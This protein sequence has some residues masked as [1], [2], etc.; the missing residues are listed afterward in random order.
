MLSE[1]KG[2]IQK[3]TSLCKEL[4][5]NYDVISS[6]ICGSG[7]FDCLK[8][9]N[10]CDCLL[11]LKDYDRGIR[12]SYRKLRKNVNIA[13][14][15]VDK[16]L[17]EIDVRKGK[18]GDFIAGRILTPYLPI[19]NAD[20]LIDMESIF[21][22]R[23]IKEEIENLIIEYGELSRSLVIRPEY[24]ALV[25]MSKRAKTFPPLRYHYSR[26]FNEKQKN[27]NLKKIMKSFTKSIEDLAQEGLVKIDG[28]KVLLSYGYIDRVISKRTFRKFVNIMELSKAS[29]YSYLLHGK[30]GF[31]DLDTISKELMYRIRHDIYG[32]VKKSEIENPKNYLSMKVANKEISLD[33]RDSIAEVLKKISPAARIEIT[34]LAGVLNEVYIVRTDEDRLVAKK[35]TDWHCFKWF[36]LNI[37]ALG[38]KT[39]YLSGRTRLENELGINLYLSKNHITVPSIFHVSLPKRILFREYVDGLLFSEIVKK[40][41]NKE[42]ISE[43]AEEYF[44]EIGKIFSKTHKLGVE[45]GDSKPENFA[46]DQK[47]NIYALDL[48][49]SK[50]NGDFAWDIAEFLFYSGH[51]AIVP[52]IGLKRMIKSFIDGYA[53]SGNINI[54]QKATSLSYLKVFSLWTTP[55]VIYAITEIVHESTK[56]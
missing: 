21:K 42:K 26:I 13:F 29:L 19:I 52:K 35:F 34:P 12:Y 18:I 24:F 9:D 22:K 4:S 50:K 23:V 28:D 11:I 48:E 56:R 2:S 6:C 51:Y 37:V 31:F 3:I 5:N 53:E 27:A 43:E 40:N 16:E 49:Q 45:L 38:T 46:I 55:Q 14:L 15:I 7:V 44:H 20:Y 36:A 10:L 33:D 47:G 54:L 39:F 1:S 41:I 30:A 25:R 17:F 8:E 32:V